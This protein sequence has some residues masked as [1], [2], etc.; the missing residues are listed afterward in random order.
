MRASLMDIY[1]VEGGGGHAPSG[2]LHWDD[3]LMVSGSVLLKV[4]GVYRSSVIPSA[5]LHPPPLR[6]SKQP[7]SPACLVITLS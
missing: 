6:A 3:A 4:P 5:S 7:S 2:F 1:S